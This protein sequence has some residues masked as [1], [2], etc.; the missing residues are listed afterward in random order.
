MKVAPLWAL[1]LALVVTLAGCVSGQDASDAP[2]DDSAQPSGYSSNLGIERGRMIAQNNCAS[3]H[4][5]GTEGRSKH[6][7]A[8]PFRDLSENYPVRN[9]EEA[10]AEGIVAGHPDMPVFQFDPNSI[11]DLLDYLES[12]QTLRDT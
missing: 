4:A 10:L 2:Q 7:D 11:N 1:P 5:I 3:C 12:I 6:P 8:K 9:L